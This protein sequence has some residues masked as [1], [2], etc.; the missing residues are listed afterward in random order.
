MPDRI[1]LALGGNALVS[2]PDRIS[3]ADQAR[4]IA[5]TAQHVAGLRAMGCEIV[6]THGNGPQVGRALE[7]EEWSGDGFLLDALGADTQG[8]LGYALQ[9]A[10]GNELCRRG[11]DPRV[12]TVITQVVVDPS[13]PAF[14]RPHKPI[15][16]AFPEAEA[17][18]LRE[19]LGWRMVHEAGRGWRRVVPSPQPRK[20]IEAWAIRLLLES[21]AVV[22]GCGGGGVPVIESEFGLAGVSAVIDKDR[23]SALLAVELRARRLVF[24]TGVPV[25]YRGFGTPEARPIE[26]LTAAEAEEMLRSGEFPPGSMGPKIEGAVAFLR[27][28]GEEVRITS[29]PFISRALSGEAGTLIVS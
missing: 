15:G 19:H 8:G 22:I 28:G 5:T 2:A 23:A 18:R 29:P 26:R 25:L 9:Q 13:D 20:I 24:T 10:L 7:T 6:L 17:K 16:R 21:G 27:R 11:L 1:V 12:V 3:P 14:T 4:A